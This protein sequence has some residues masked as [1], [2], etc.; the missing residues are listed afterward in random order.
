MAPKTG[1]IKNSKVLHPALSEKDLATHP[2]YVPGSAEFSGSPLTAELPKNIAA[3]SKK[4]GL[5]HLMMPPSMTLLKTTPTGAISPAHDPESIANAWANAWANTILDAKGVLPPK[6]KKKNTALAAKTAG[7]DS[8]LVLV[9]AIL[10]AK[11]EVAATGGLVAGLGNGGA[12]VIHGFTT[13]SNE[14]LY[15]LKLSMPGKTFTVTGRSSLVFLFQKLMKRA[16]SYLE[17][18]QSRATRTEAVLK[19]MRCLVSGDPI[20][21]EQAEVPTPPKTKW[22]HLMEQLD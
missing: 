15:S 22:D 19:Q 17:L 20:A 2:N 6:A 18:L 11:W 5:P 4:K 16:K 14:Y 12:L 3:A 8:L 1:K 9:S 7:K 13:Q 21:T 10:P